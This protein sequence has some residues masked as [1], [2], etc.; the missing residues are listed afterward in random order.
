MRGIVIEPLP[1]TNFCPSPEIIATTVW[2]NSD[3]ETSW[4]AVR[5]KESLIALQRTQFSLIFVQTS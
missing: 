5:R 4:H 2:Y 1:Q 3:Y